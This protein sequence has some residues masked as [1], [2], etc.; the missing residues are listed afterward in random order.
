MNQPRYDGRG[1]LPQLAP[2]E[3][4]ASRASGDDEVGSP[5]ILENQHE[6]Q[7][8]KHEEA[9]V[10]EERWRSLHE[11]KPALCNQSV[12]IAFL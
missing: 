6:L 1:H 12:Y 2:F 10:E 7:L 3:A 9:L 5:E 11:V 8:E 4:G